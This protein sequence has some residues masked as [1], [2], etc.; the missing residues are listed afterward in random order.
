MS[1]PST[2]FGIGL[3]VGAGLCLAVQYF[4]KRQAK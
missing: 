2:A 4:I 1:N 3:I